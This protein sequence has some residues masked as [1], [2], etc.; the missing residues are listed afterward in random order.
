MKRALAFLCGLLLAALQ[1][2][3]EPIVDAVSRVAIPVSGLDR[4]AGFYARAL[5][6][7]ADEGGAGQGVI[8]RLG[9]ESIELVL[10][11]G[12]KLPADSRSNDRWF[13]HLAIVVSDI[14]CAYAQ[15]LHAGATAISARPQTLPAWNPNA[16][17]IR[18]VYFRDP[19]GHPLE[20]IQF[21]A[22]K[23]APRWQD[24]DRLFLGI[25][26]SAI[27][28][29][30]TESSLA[31]YRNRLSLHVVGTSENWGIEQERLSG[32]EGAHVRITSLRA[33]SGLGIEFLQYLMPRDGRPMPPDTR[34]DDLWAEQILMIGQQPR[35]P[36]ERLHDP[37]GHA[38]RIVTP[39]RER[40]P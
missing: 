9:V 7:E 28:V 5:T 30:D 32:V 16:G 39:N 19:D 1:A 25:D 22:G 8:M 21:P 4:A 24:K 13:Q 34:L 17:G 10:A 40:L 37:D 12:R 11:G 27:A 31:L 38:I 33:Q 18:A 14:D 36:G 20:L 35:G 23:G 2:H 29:R 26:H 3:A 15:V 6:F